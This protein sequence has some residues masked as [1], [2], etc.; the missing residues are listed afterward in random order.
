MKNKKLLYGKGVYTQGEYSSKENGK[1]SHVYG[2]WKGIIER[3][4]SERSLLRT[5]TYRGCTVCDEWLHFQTFAKWLMNNKFQ[6][7]GYHIDKDILSPES[8]IYSPETC[9]LVPPEINILF[10]ANDKN[11][12]LYP[13]GVSWRKERRRYQAKIRRHGRTRHIGYFITCDDAEAAYIHAKEA[14]VKEIA[15]KW[16]GLIEDRA[17]NGLMNWS[18]K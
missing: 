14:Y 1:Q 9:V 2:I 4:Y 8:K 6:G 5:P 15:N 17:Y 18:V 10:V 12:G 7:L 16:K 3:C 11:R 13:V